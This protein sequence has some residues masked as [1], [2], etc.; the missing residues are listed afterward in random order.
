MNRTAARQRMTELCTELEQ[1]AREVG[2]PLCFMEVCGTHTVS[3]CRSGVH[4]LMPDTVRLVSGP[5]C[6]V[7]VT[8]QR[9]I[10]ALIRLGH[11][12]DVILTTYGDMLRV[13]GSNGDSLQKARSEGADVRVVN[14]TMDAVDIAKANPTRQV[15]FA[16]VGFETTAPAS[17]VA[18][19]AASACTLDNFTIMPAHKLVIPAM[20]ALLQDP[21]IKVDGFLCP[22]HVS[23][24]IGSDAYR[25]VVEQH[26]KPC[27]ISGFEPL[28]IMQGV[29]QLVRQLKDDCPSI[30]NLY[31]IAVTPA[32]NIHAQHALDRVFMPSDTPWRALATIPDSGLELRPEFARFDALT[33]FEITLGE[34]HEPPGCR[35]GEV[36]TGKC[37]PDECRLFGNV[38]TPVNPIGPCMVSS[39]GSCQAWFK[40]RRRES[41]PDKR[42]TTEVKGHA[43][44]PAKIKATS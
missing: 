13:T 28:Q 33:R 20:L 36:I 12:P 2:R 44:H 10:D 41:S 26:R 42:S 14:S 21:D 34:D 25:P 9:H 40:Y 8:A 7:C 31:P 35:C 23:V 37:L 43:T 38:C 11:I 6:P 22:G 4:A 3:A 27:V 16:S 15:V 1:T 17:A 19:M 30:E 24:I 18:V 29:L 5:G 32:G 39:E